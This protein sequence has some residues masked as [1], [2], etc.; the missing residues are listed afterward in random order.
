MTGKNPNISNFE[1]GKEV[2]ETGVVE[3]PVQFEISP[4]K[5]RGAPRP[6]FKVP[7]SVNLHRTNGGSTKTSHPTRWFSGLL[8][9]IKRRLPGRLY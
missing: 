6:D 3:L 1:A 4:G 2:V 8:L 7:G 5:S 9:P